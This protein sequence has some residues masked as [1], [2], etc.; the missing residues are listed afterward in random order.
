[1]P[2]GA[3]A[4]H[5]AVQGGERSSQDHSRESFRWR[6]RTPCHKGHASDSRTRTRK[7]KQN[8]TTA[9]ALWLKSRR[10]PAASGFLPVNKAHVQSIW[11]NMCLLQVAQAPSCAIKHLAVLIPA[12][13]RGINAHAAPLRD[14]SPRAPRRGPAGW[15]CPARCWPGRPP[16][17]RASPAGLRAGLDGEA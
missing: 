1:M 4:K 7:S 5:L 13:T 15:V 17:S 2:A 3:G 8:A 16:V 12:G 6:R 11:G 9:H 14:H 10:C